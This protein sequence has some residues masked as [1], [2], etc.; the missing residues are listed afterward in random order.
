[1]GHLLITRAGLAPALVVLPRKCAPLG[2]A[3]ALVVSIAPALVVS[4]A[5]A[6]ATFF[7]CVTFIALAM[8]QK[9]MAQG[10]VFIVTMPGITQSPGFV[11]DLLAVHVYDTVVFVNSATAPIAIVAVDNSFS[12]SAIA[13]GQQ[14][15]VTFNSAGA[16][17][18]H[19]NSPTPRIFGEIVVVPNTVALLP[20]PA[21][22]AQETAIAFIKAGKMPPDTVWQPTAPQVQA[23]SVTRPLKNQTTS[24]LS[25][26][27]LAL[28]MTFVR[29]VILVV[30]I[31][32]ALFVSG[33]GGLGLYRR[34]KSRKK[35]GDEDE[36]DTDE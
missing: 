24:S 1:M 18:Y 25:V 21:P 15:K 14:W 27:P 23:S 26:P 32:L 31:L 10:N 2:L 16:F 36:D 22:A 9:V 8:P 3:P 33:L 35:E 7:I 28:L 19:E 30:I 34:Q 11:P 6:L 13:P 5:P 4:I 29:P 17:E 20:S 12:S